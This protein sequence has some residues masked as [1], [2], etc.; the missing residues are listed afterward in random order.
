MCHKNLKKNLEKS[1]T[2]FFKITKT[3]KGEKILIFFLFLNWLGPKSPTVSAEGCSPPQKLEKS[4]T[5]NHI[6]TL[7]LSSRLS[8]LTTLTQT[9]EN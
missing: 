7:Y 6:F 4:R 3:K 2:N 8:H 9:T 5:I 1:Q